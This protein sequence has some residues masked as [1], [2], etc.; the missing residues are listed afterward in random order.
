[1]VNVAFSQL[2][3]DGMSALSK[4]WH[5]LEEWANSLEEWANSLELG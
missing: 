5:S 4:L 2:S 3:V 1:M